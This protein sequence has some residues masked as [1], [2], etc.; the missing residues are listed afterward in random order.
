MLRAAYAILIAG[1]AVAAVAHPSARQTAITTPRAHFGFDLGDDYQLAN[2]KQ[3]A[4]Y[5][6]TLDAESDRMVLQEIGRTS[7]NRPP[8]MAIVTSPEN[9]RNLARYR[10]ISRRL[11]L[12]QN[13]SDTEARALAREGKA[14][15]MVSSEL[16]EL[17]QVADRIL[18]MR[19]G[20]IVA[21]LPRSTT[22][23]QIMHYAAV[24]Q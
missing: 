17:L 9:H 16:P 24:G 3:I 1:V 23:E 13:L 2:Y 14:I 11:A 18:V 22:Q 19:E 12:A 10:D 15:L 20:E 6:R 7:E 8:L 4:D 21:E 5:W